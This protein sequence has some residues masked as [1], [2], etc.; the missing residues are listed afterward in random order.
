MRQVF[1]TGLT[2]L[3]LAAAAVAEAHPGHGVDGGSWSLP[4]YASE[5]V[6][7]GTA[8]ALATIAAAALAWRWRQGRPARRPP[9][10]VPA[11]PV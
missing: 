10:A 9:A 7:L 1:V 4:H 6:H 5:P 3:L 2:G 11:E 8:A